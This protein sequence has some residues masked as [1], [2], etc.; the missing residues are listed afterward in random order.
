MA[1][2]I[3]RALALVRPP[4]H[5]AERNRAMGFC[6]YNN[7]AVGGR[8][9]PGARRRARGDR[10][11][12]RPSRQRH[13]AH[14]RG[15]SAACSTSRRT[16][17]RSIRAPARPT[18]SARG[19]GRGFTVNLPLE[20]GAVDDDYQLVFGEVMCRSSAV[21]ARPGAGLGRLRRARARSARRHAPD[22]AAVRGD[23]DGA[24][25]RWRTSA[26][27]GGWWRSR[28]A[29]T[30]LHALAESLHR[31]RPDALGSEQS[32]RRRGRRREP[33]DPREAA[34][35]SPRP[36]QRWRRSGA[37]DTLVNADAA[38]RSAQ[39]LEPTSPDLRCGIAT[40]A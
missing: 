5:H 40:V 30:I 13:A 32:S 8:A 17:S 10:R 21:Q 4:G 38:R 12:R 1:G 33:V 7:V 39:H 29:A 31:R 35:P 15:G 24:A 34:R 19:A 25:A 27:A 18:K 11:L 20:V 9:R 37:S 16:S 3:T 23:D 28:R 6:L 22:D 26:A 36:R 2:R 14:L